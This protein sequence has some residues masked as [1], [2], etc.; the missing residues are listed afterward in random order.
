MVLF[1]FKGLYPDEH[2]LVGNHIYDRDTKAEFTL[3]DDMS[4]IAT[5]F[6]TGHIPIWTTL[7]NESMF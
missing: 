1:C 7:T 6:W 3:P 5:M 4:T 2:G